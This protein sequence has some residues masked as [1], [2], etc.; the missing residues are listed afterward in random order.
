MLSKD[1]L[2]LSPEVLAALA[3]KAPL[4]A[5]ESTIISHGMPY[6]H[7][8]HCAMEVEEVVRRQGAVP[9]TVAL[10]HG[11]VCVGL[12]GEDIEELAQAGAKARKVSRRDIPFVLAQKGL[13]S[14]TVAGTM[15][16]SALAGIDVFVTGGLGGVH[17][18]FEETMDVSADLRELGRT[19]VAVVSAGVKNI[20]DIPRTLEYL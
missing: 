18:G 14:T 8:K 1:I 3:R 9:A 7:N 16:C 20:L 11:Q 12:T 6:P 17:R 19:P 4:V 10:M 15:I 5:L 2:R 13:G